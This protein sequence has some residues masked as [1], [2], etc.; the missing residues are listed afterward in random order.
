MY[1][2]TPGCFTVVLYIVHH[3]FPQGLCMSFISQVTREQHILVQKLCQVSLKVS[4][5]ALTAPLPRPKGLQ[6]VQVEGYWLQVGQLETRIPEGY[7]L[8]PSVKENLRNLARIVCGR[9]GQLLWYICLYCSTRYYF[10]VY[11][12]TSC[13]LFT[14]SPT[15]LLNT[16]PTVVYILLFLV[17]YVLHIEYYTSMLC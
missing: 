12:T 14:S 10:D 5:N 11:G 1:C 3:P 17:Q 8:T 9:L 6:C 4:A 16:V 13:M 7:I 15:C 2:T